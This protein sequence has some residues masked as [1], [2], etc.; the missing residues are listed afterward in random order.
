MELI[1]FLENF[2]EF[3][4]AHHFF[5]I[6]QTGQIEKVCCQ[7]STTEV[8][9]FDKTKEAIARHHGIQQ[10]KS[11]DALKIL[12]EKK[13]IDFIEFKGLAKFIDWV[14]DRDAI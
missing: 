14:R 2:L 9:D 6:K 7:D 12:P 4:K 5:E 10:P 8:I 1:R 3:G 11:C 13:T